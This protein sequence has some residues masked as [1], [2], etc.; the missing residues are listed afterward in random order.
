MKIDTDFVNIEDA[1]GSR[2]TTLTAE[3]ADTVAYASLVAFRRILLE[4]KSLNL[5]SSS[6]WLKDLVF[7]LK[8]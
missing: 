3:Q 7:F 8:L 6:V 5:T 4:W 2:G 1:R